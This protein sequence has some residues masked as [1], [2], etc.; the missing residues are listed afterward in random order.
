MVR[1]GE[2]RVVIPAG[3]VPDCESCVELCCTGPNAIVSLRL[4]DIAALM[5]AGLEHAIVRRDLDEATRPTGKSG[6]IRHTWARREADSS[7]FH[8]AF[9]VLARDRTH[10][11]A[12]LTE[13]RRCGAWPAWPL[14]CARYPYALDLQMKVVFWASGCTSKMTLPVGEAPP[15][16]RT[17][18]RAVVDAYNERVKDIITVSLARAELRDIG[19]L[20]H[21]DEAQLGVLPG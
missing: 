6:T 19:V 4:R 12:L 16:V 13:D 5:D 2:L 3:E 21:I 11:C 20:R 17:L 8:R 9:P 18:V 7:V 14:S 1:L 15:R 10:T